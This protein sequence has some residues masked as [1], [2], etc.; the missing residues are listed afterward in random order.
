MSAVL[1]RRGLMQLSGAGLTIALFSGCALPAIPRRPAPSLDDA[2]G[3]I[4]H[5]AGRYTLW[6]PRVEMGQGVLTGLKQIA[7]AELGVGWNEVDVKLPGVQLQGTGLRPLLAEA[8]YRMAGWWLLQTGTA[9]AEI[10]FLCG[11]ADQSHF[12]RE[13]RLRSGMTPG[14]YRRDFACRAAGV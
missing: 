9:L 12:T 7:C 2:L 6:L 8:R 13:F 1:T 14:D 10:G 5:E 3:W 4:R 11:Y